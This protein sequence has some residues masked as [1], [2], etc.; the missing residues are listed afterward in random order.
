MPAWPLLLLAG[1]GLAVSLAAAHAEPVI[2]ETAVRSIPIR[3]CVIGEDKNANGLADPGERGAPTFTHPQLFGA[4]N[5]D[6]VLLARHLRF[7]DHTYVPGAGLAFRSAARRSA[8][9]RTLHFPIIPDQEPHNANHRYGDVWH[10]GRE[11]KAGAA[12][13]GVTEWQKTYAACV[14][15]WRRQHGV[16]DLGIVAVVARR[17]VNGRGKPVSGGKGFSGRKRILLQDGI[18]R[19]C[20]RID[21]EV[22]G[23]C[24]PDED[25]WCRQRKVCDPVDKLGGHEIGHTL[26]IDH[27]LGFRVRKGLRHTCDDWA[28]IMRQGRKDADGD[29]KLDNYRLSSSIRFVIDSG[30]NGRAC[31][32]GRPSGA[33]AAFDEDDEIAGPID[34]GRLVFAAAPKVVGCVELADGT[35]CTAGG[36][37]RVDRLKDARLPALDLHLLRIQARARGGLEIEHELG[38]R[39]TAADVAAVGSIDYVTLLDLDDDARTGGAPARLGLDTNFAGAEIVTRVRVSATRAGT[40]VGRAVV[41]TVWRFD[42]G[43]FR[44]LD[45]PDIVAR[46]APVA[47]VAHANADFPKDDAA[48]THDVVALTLPR[49]VVPAAPGRLRAQALVRAR[50]DDP[51]AA[52]DRLD[53]PEGA[54]GAVFDLRT[55]PGAVCKIARA[56]VPQG[57]MVGLR[58]DGLVPLRPLRVFLGAVPVAHGASDGTG[59]TALT[60][61]V[62]VRARTGPRLITVQVVGTALTAGCALVVEK[63]PATARNTAG[64]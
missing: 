46:R 25:P 19:S 35:P 37:V 11:L 17:I 14:S 30:A 51:R 52:S 34:Q 56:R 28:N 59:R 57:G 31:I 60:F 22:A 49:T 36:D 41:A 58:A 55:P 29:G 2:A 7:A 9:N 1:I 4:P 38:G 54:Q 15:A 24:D 48:Y 16:A 18:W 53:T 26:P 6:G 12:P 44:Q 13:D 32:K 3:W 40:R 61:R 10:P 21:L 43:T 50:G 42:G 39:L 23:L 45:D 8:G 33:P 47:A 27:G 5:S 64:R 63:A 62:P 20:V